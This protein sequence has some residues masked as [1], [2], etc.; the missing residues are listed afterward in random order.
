MSAVTIATDPGD[1]F[2]RRAVYAVVVIIVVI[3][4]VVAIV[5]PRKRAVVSSSFIIIVVVIVIV[6]CCGLEH[7]TLTCS[8]Q[9]NGF[10]NLHHNLY[11]ATIWNPTQGRLQGVL[12]LFGP[13]LS[14]LAIPVHLV[15]TCMR[16]PTPR[17]PGF[18]GDRGS[19]G[20][21]STLSGHSVW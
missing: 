18:H 19:V 16:C 12:L 11:P 21:S 4:I 3:V 8:A 9:G 10:L 1:S 14:P 20:L 5:R 7:R 17:L 2:L 13:V 15:L 6:S